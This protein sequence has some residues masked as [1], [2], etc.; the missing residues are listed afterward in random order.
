MHLFRDGLL[1]STIISHRTSV[2]SVLHHWKYDPA[3]D[4][5]IKLLIRA[6]RLEWP[7]QRQIMPKWDLHL[8]LSA[9]MSPPFASE[10][11]ILSKVGVLVTGSRIPGQ[12]PTSIPGSRMDHRP[13]YRTSQSRGTT[14]DAMSSQTARALSTGYGKNPEKLSMALHPLES[15]HKGHHES[16]ISKW[17]VETV[18]EAYTQAD[19]DQEDSITG[20]DVRVLSASWAYNCQWHFLTFCQL[21]IGGHQESSRI[22]IYAIWPAYCWWDINIGSC[23][24]RTTSRGSRTSSPTSIAY[25]TCIKPLL[26]HA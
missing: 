5:H 23:S 20:H 3:T 22:H 25:T 9:L 17:I 4:P 13:R 26:R 1:P 14:E 8:V 21:C 15:N 10:E 11:E 7:V 18:K 16:H 6:F 24:G 12:E 2:A 19:R